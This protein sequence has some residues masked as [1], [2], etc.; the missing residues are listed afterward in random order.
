MKNRFLNCFEN[1]AIDQ[2]LSARNQAGR[3]FVCFHW[4]IL[5]FFVDK[6]VCFFLNP[7]FL[8]MCNV[9]ITTESQ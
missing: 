4:V 7:I 1:K 9:L 3:K 6:N 2:Q 5:N 8:R